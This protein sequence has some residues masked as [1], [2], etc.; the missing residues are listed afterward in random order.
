MA[1][2]RHPH[3]PNLCSFIK[4]AWNQAESIRCKKLRHPDPSAPFCAH[5]A[6]LAAFP[7]CPTCRAPVSTSNLDKHVSRCIAVVPPVYVHKERP[8]D[9]DED[10]DDEHSPRRTMPS[11]PSAASKA[12]AALADGGFHVPSYATHPASPGQAMAA[13]IAHEL[14]PTTLAAIEAAIALPWHSLPAE[15][16]PVSYLPPRRQE[17]KQKQLEN[18][19]SLV[20]YVLQHAP[21]G[22]CL[23]LVDFCSGSGH[24]GLLLAHLLP[25]HSVVLVEHN[26]RQCQLAEARIHALHL[27]NARVVHASIYDPALDSLAFDVGITL[28]AC[29][30]L[31]DAAHIRCIQHRAAYVLVSCCVGKIMNAL[32]ATQKPNKTT[33]DPRS[34][35]TYPRSAAVRA[36]LHPAQY[37]ALAGGGDWGTFVRSE[38]ATRHRQCKLLIEADRQTWAQQ[39]HG[40]QTR[41]VLLAPWTCTPKHDACLGWCWPPPT[42]EP[43]IACELSWDDCVRAIRSQEL[44]I[45]RRRPDAQADMEAFAANLLQTWRSAADFVLSSKFGLA[46]DNTVPGQWSVNV[47]TILA[48]GV[49]KALVPNDFPYWFQPGIAHWVLWKINADIGP[50]DL[51]DAEHTLRRDLHALDILSFI[52]PAHLK[53]VPGVAHAHFLVHH[54]K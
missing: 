38:Q 45:L 41:L 30:P 28:H 33:N 52:N 36:L 49:Q 12:M 18:M 46:V 21:P 3:P 24:T 25:Q 48:V 27:T 6:A 51:R 19:V 16:N 5:H 23:T 1:A 2:Q 15:V 29:G 47:S 34:V 13:S 35:V 53:S 50:D 11:I 9:C 54:P 31:T 32:D 37:S 42:A 43:A 22:K 40:Y 4:S 10:D 7:L 8:C 44:A 14:E 39:E 20:Q 17:R 26:A